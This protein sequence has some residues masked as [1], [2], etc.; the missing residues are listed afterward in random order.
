VLIVWSLEGG[1][2]GKNE[3]IAKGRT[4]IAKKPLLL[5]SFILFLSDK[6]ATKGSVTAS[7][8]LDTP[9]A[10]PTIVRPK[11][12]GPLLINSGKLTPSGGI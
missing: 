3:N 8:N 1:K 12:T 2:K 5:P 4:L 10:R 6:V 9:S 7:N 11:K